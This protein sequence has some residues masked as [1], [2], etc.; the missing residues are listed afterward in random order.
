METMICY[1]KEEIWDK[2]IGERGNVKRDKSEAGLHPF[3]TGEGIKQARQSKKRSKPFQPIVKPFSTSDI[4]LLH[5][6]AFP[7]TFLYHRY[8]KQR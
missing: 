7:L 5:F 8:M 2:H 3:V 1:T 6:V 4:V